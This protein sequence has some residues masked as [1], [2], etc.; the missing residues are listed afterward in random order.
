MKILSWNCR[1][2]GSPQAVRALLRL[3]RIENPQIVFLMETRLK[4]NEVEGVRS[5]LGFKNC[6]TVDCR[7]VGRE[8]AGG[9]SLMW[10]EHVNI[11]IISYSLNHIH[12]VCDDEESGE[13]WGLTGIY[14]YPEEQHKKKTWELIDSLGRQVSGK[15][16]CCGDFNDI[17]DSQEKIGG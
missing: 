12:G 6:L 3:T 2:L 7:G 17:L 15:W 10:M 1:G 13:G 5:K 9:L 11:S 14:G 16:F 4:V 8:R